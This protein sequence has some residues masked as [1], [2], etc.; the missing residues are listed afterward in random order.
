MAPRAIGIGVGELDAIVAET[1][2]EASEHMRIPARWQIEPSARRQSGARRAIRGTLSSSTW[3]YPGVGA[4]A[5]ALWT[6]HAWAIDAADISPLLI[7][8]I[9]GNAM[10]QEHSA[11]IAL[12]YRTAHRVRQQH[13]PGGGVSTSRPV[14]PALIMDEANSFVRD[15]KE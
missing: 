13:F 9:T 6:L 11:G 15:S 3:S 14:T 7:F 5:M 4:T 8:S 2:G 12:P 10:R 1:R